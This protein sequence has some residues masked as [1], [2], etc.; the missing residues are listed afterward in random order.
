MK[1]ESPP[2]FDAAVAETLSA[3]KRRGGSVLVV[4]P[5]EVSHT[6]I[7]R[8]FLDGEAEEI[9]VRT[10]RSTSGGNTVDRV[11]ERTIPTRSVSASRSAG[12]KSPTSVDIESVSEDLR[13]EMRDAAGEASSLRVCFDS[14]RPFVDS[15]ADRRLADALDAIRSTARETD[16]VVHF[17]LPAMQAAVPSALLDAVDLVVEVR[18]QGDA[19][20]QRWQLGSEEPTTE[21]VTV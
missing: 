18:H 7:C 3:V 10:E 4:G 1:F 9:A 2:P 19:T 11:I 17:H 6:D 13:T 12:E 15:G 14:L 8:R 5:S 16:A 21:W 20:Y